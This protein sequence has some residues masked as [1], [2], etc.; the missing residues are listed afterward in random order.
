MMSMN[1]ILSPANGKP[2]IVPSQDII[3]GLYYMTMEREGMPGQGMAFADPAEV[4]HALNS[5]AVT[6]HTK[7]N[8]RIDTYDETGERVTIRVE[9]TPGRLK[10]GHL[11]PDNPKIRFSLINR[12][13]TK[14]E[15]SN[16][17]DVVYRHCGQRDG[18]LRRP[19]DGT[20][21]RQR[22]PGRYLVR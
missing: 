1:N 3:L 19:S 9:T 16:V 18:D 7:V 15:V 20:W 10:L 13:M 4:D 5:G 8:A 21:F 12:L 11:L 6:L 22:L 14:K 2:I 17:I